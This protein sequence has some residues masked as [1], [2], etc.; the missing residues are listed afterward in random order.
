MAGQ[1][2]GANHLGQICRIGGQDRFPRG[3]GGF[4]GA[5]GTA[6]VGIGGVLGKDRAHQLVQE[7]RAGGKPIGSLLGDPEALL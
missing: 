1:A 2:A 3:K 5:E 7:I 4:E 6:A